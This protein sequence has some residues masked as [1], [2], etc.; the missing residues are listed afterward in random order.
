M[1]RTWALLL[2]L[3]YS[4]ILKASPSRGVVMKAARKNE[5]TSFVDEHR[6]RL[7]ALLQDLRELDGGERRVGGLGNEHRG[8]GEVDAEKM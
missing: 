2:G 1:A 3:A 8:K 7:V 4:R 5:V 6:G